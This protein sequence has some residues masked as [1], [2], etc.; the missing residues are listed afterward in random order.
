M[1]YLPS[2]IR[3][4]SFIAIV[5]ATTIFLTACGSGNDNKTEFD[6]ESSL[7]ASLVISSAAFEDGDS[8][9]VEYTC[10]GNNTS[11]PLRWSDVP[12]GTRAIAILVDD[13]DAL[14]G[15]FRHWSVYNIPSGSRSLPAA[16]PKMVKLKDSTRQ[17]FNSFD[18]VGYSGP[19]PPEGQEHEYVFFIYALSEPLDLDDDATAFDVSTALRGKVVGTGSFS[20][21]YARR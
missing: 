16:Q 4:F 21:M 12:G 20:G 7:I 19:C 6:P 14:V 5:L 10:D 17:A 3:T 13:P 9:P 18:N 15:I 11:P 1:Q 2:Q 8:I